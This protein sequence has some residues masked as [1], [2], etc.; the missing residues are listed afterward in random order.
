M[1]MF[2]KGRPQYPRRNDGGRFRDTPRKKDYEGTISSEKI[3]VEHK[4]F[5]LLLK[6]N[7]RGKFLRII[8]ESSNKSDTIIIPSSGLRELRDVLDTYVKMTEEV[9]KSE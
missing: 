5:Y 4:T 3:V 7:Q 9:E 8:E 2:H 1:G 6:E